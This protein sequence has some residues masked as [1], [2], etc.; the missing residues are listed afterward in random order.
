MAILNGKALSKG[1]S[2][3]LKKVLL[4]PVVRKYL[5]I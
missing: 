5:D 1:T 2:L 4:Q 3:L